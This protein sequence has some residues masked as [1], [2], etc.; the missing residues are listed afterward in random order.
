MNRKEKFGLLLFILGLWVVL[1]IDPESN[2]ILCS[3]L[4]TIG[5]WV[6]MYGGKE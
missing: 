2:Y 3:L 4:S 6:F 5:I 1:P